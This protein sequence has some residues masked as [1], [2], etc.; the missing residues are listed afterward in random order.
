MVPDHEMREITSEEALRAVIGSPGPAAAGKV[1]HRLDETDRRWLA[2]CRF[3]LLG[4]AADDGSCD[5][6]PKGDPSGFVQV[7]DDTTIAM[8]E[9]AGNR[10]AD[11]YLNILRNP[12]VGMLFMVPGRGDTLRINGHARIVGDAS[13]FDRMVVKGH[14][15]KLALVVSVEE[16]FYHCAKAFMRSELWD[17]RTWAADEL[18]SR[19]QIARRERPEDSLETLEAYYEPVNY[20]RGLYPAP[21]S[22]AVQERTGVV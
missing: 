9:R 5:V 3:L 6:S 17:P 19:A 22:S 10:R 21:D 16:V 18:P 15:P 20:S 4:T 13:F 7:L 8:P 14:R 11:G 12:R 2:A 1:R